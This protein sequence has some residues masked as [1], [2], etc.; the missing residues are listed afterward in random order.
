LSAFYT[1]EPDGEWSLYFNNASF[2]IQYK[3]PGMPVIINGPMIRVGQQQV[4]KVTPVP[5]SVI[6]EDKRI[7]NSILSTIQP[8]HMIPFDPSDCLHSYQPTSDTNQQNTG[9]SFLGFI[10]ERLKEWGVVFNYEFKN[11]HF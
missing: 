2:S 6:N 10:A 8:K 7:I 3:Y 4:V 1:P 11:I 5:Q 9:Y